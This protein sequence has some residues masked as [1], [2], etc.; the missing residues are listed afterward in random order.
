M[1]D[2]LTRLACMTLLCASLPAPGQQTGLPPA[3]TAIRSNENAQQGTEPPALKEY[4]LPPNPAAAVFP[5]SPVEVE[6]EHEYTLPELVDIAERA[7]PE[8]RIAWVTAKNAALA[9]GIAASTYFPR[10]SATIVG[11]YQG[12]SGSSSAFG[13]TTNG[14]ASVTGTVSAVS[15]EW[16][17]FDFGGRYHVVDAT[18][19]L[20]KVSSIA[21]TGEHQAVIHEV[22]VA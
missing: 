12:S 5:V 15:M 1:P 22:C 7:H 16:L 20:A 21:F 17:L 9:S 18:R 10:V 3:P 4:I 11:G 6:H 14:S 2:V 19:K 8:T 13:A